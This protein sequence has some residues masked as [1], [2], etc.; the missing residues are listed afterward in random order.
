[1]TTASARQDRPAEPRPPANSPDS[2]RFTP[3]PKLRRRPSLIA[4]G[5]SA[6]CFG[7][8]IAAWAWSSTTSTQEVL[9]A[10]DTIHQGE[11]ITAKDLERV[12]ISGDQSLRPVPGTSF[13][14][15][16]GQRAAL[17]VAAGSLLTAESTTS[18]P[19][20]P[21][22]QSVV[23]IAL[24]PAQV[25]AMPLHGGDA[26]RIVTT[27]GE[28]GEAT[29]PSP[30]FTSA[31]VVGTR[32]DETTGN[33]VVDVVVPHADAGLLAARAATGNVALVLDSGAE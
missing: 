16:V 23:G 32:L 24:T 11:V 7:A 6:V 22:G 27:P 5:V 14:E 12:R 19:L 33:T 4:G 28:N 2:A 31:V 17:D 25:P 15:I 29:V 13:D 20:P 21:K 8:V 10:R 30:P 26:V 1:V 9:A 3:P 18:D